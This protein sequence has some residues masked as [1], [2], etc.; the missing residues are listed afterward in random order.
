[1]PS[2]PI[3]RDIVN[4]LKEALNE[5]IQNILVKIDLEELGAPKNYE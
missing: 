4:K 1:V 5:L 3:T 2:G